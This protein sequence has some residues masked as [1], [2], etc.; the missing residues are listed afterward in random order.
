MNL[1]SEPKDLFE[2]IKK[3]LDP[4]SNYFFFKYY[5]YFLKN[6]TKLRYIRGLIE[7]SLISEFQKLGKR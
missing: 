6:E 1:N 5:I 2:Q 7:K 4:S 3:L